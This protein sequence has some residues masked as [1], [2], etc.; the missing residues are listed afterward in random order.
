MTKD[1]LTSTVVDARA[2][3]S[4][5]SLK[6][7][8]EDEVG[9]FECATWLHLDRKT[10]QNMVKWIEAEVEAYAQGTLF[11]VESLQEAPHNVRWMPPQP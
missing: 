1:N 8:I 2:D 11:Q 7:W 4:S 9:R 10:C 3:R 6:V 5:V